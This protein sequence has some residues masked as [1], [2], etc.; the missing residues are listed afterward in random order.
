MW[1]A[2][3]WDVFMW[4][5]KGVVVG[6]WRRSRWVGQPP[7]SPGKIS[8]KV[9]HAC[10][11]AKRDHV[12]ERAR[13]SALLARYLVKFG[14]ESAWSRSFTHMVALGLLTGV[15]YQSGLDYYKNINEQYM[16]LVPKGK[17]MP[18]NP[19]LVMVSVDCDEYASML[20]AK[21]WDAVSQYLSHGVERLVK[22]E[23]GCCLVLC[24][25]TA[26]LAVPLVRQL[27]P[28]LPIL[29]IAD[30]TARAIKAK[31][32]S[33]VG[34]LGTEPT[35]REDY[36]KA[37]LARHGVE[38]IV[39]DSDADLQQV[40]QFIMDELGFGEFKEST[41]AFFAA[42]VRQLRARGAEGVILGCTEIELLLRQEDTPEVPLFASAELHIAA[43]ARVAAGRQRV[44][45]YEPPA[46]SPPP[47]DAPSL[48]PPHPAAHAAHAAPP[49]PHLDAA[50]VRRL[51]PVEVALEAAALAL[52]SLSDG[53]G[54]MP[55]RG[56]RPWP[57]T[58]LA[59]ALTLA[60]IL[61]CILSF[62][63]PSLPPSP[64]LAPTLTA[65]SCPRPARCAV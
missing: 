13:P 19:S 14:H 43:A 25:N 58:P 62:A 53:S 3:V 39:P 35:M 28:T 50:A 2:G 46:D 51:L 41:R 11:E 7:R 29:H 38:C 24:S 63:S 12:S 10:E 16:K 42:Q 57:L 34:L 26:H 59:L 32:L 5:G 48:A 45:D 56:A 33:R 17:L 15:S 8:C 60:L 6:V 64:T 31:G 1:A 4:F 23:P 37:Q 52:R 30:V 61:T 9:A 54:T 20:V 21:E 55:V 18:P 22:A 47:A 36:L 44:A 40:F 49:V 65:A 27:N